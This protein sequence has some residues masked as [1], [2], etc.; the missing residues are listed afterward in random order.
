MCSG[1]YSLFVL[2]HFPALGHWRSWLPGFWNQTGTCVIG[3]QIFSPLDSDWI[4]AP[5]LLVLQLADFLASTT[6]W[7]SSWNESPALYIFLYVYFSASV[8][9][10]NPDWFKGHDI[11][12]VSCEMD[13]NWRDSES[14]LYSCVMIMIARTHKEQSVLTFSRDRLSRLR[15]WLSWWM[16]ERK[17]WGWVIWMVVLMQVSELKGMDRED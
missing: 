6:L 13:C 3:L 8:S 7:T 5:T 17:T 16:K 15:G 9:L 4:T 10:E 11:T 2:G 14:S 1:H 12:L